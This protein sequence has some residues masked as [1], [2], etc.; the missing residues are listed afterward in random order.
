MNLEQIQTA[1]FNLYDIRKSLSPSVLRQPIYEA[2]F[3]ETVG[4]NLQDAINFLEGLEA[5]LEAAA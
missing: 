2:S 4:S 3:D 1:L 5:E